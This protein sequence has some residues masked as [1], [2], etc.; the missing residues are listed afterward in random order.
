MNVV[1]FTRKRRKK[2]I[3]FHINKDSGK[4]YFHIFMSQWRGH[5][6]FGGQM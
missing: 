4:P 2:E 5:G 3:Y 1:F 6:E